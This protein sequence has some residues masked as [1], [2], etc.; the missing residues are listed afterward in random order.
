M[1]EKILEMSMGFFEKA[2]MKDLAIDGTGIGYD[3]PIS[4]SVMWGISKRDKA[5]F[6]RYLTDRSYSD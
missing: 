5:M 6:M 2:G 4:M 3:T 1:N